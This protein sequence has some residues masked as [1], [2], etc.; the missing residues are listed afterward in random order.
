MGQLG[1]MSLLVHLIILI[2]GKITI[3]VK[4]FFAR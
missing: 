1:S 2:V 3:R 4:M